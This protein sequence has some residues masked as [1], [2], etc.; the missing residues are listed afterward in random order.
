MRQV[1]SAKLD[2]SSQAKELLE[3]AP[4]K[5]K[6]KARADNNDCMIM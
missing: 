6:D 5:L 3:L 4:E 1:S 2:L